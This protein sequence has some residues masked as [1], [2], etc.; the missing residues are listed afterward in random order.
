[1][2]GD[3]FDH[4]FGSFHGAKLMFENISLR[5]ESRHPERHG[6]FIANGEFNRYNRVLFL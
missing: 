1:M 4:M 2:T 6:V 5:Q 3:T